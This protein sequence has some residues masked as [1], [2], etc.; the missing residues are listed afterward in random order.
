MYIPE[1]LNHQQARRME[2]L[3]KRGFRHLTDNEIREFH[4]LA[5]QHI[6]YMRFRRGWMMDNEIR[7]ERAA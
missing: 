4:Y 3:R 2:E 6:A 5:E 1:K 7:K